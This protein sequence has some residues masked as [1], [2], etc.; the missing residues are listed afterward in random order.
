MRR[1]MR[2]GCRRRRLRARSE[3]LQVQ[4]RRCQ[5]YSLHPCSREAAHRRHR[6]HEPRAK[7]RRGRIRCEARRKTGR[8][9]ED[10]EDQGPRRR[11]AGKRDVLGPRRQRRLR[12]QSPAGQAGCAARSH[13]GGCDQ[14][15]RGTTSQASS[16][17]VV[18]NR[19]EWDDDTNAVMEAGGNPKTIGEY[20]AAIKRTRP[21]IY[22]WEWTGRPGHGEMCGSGCG[23]PQRLCRCLPWPPPPGP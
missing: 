23:V 3:V 10:A 1:H 2:Q 16:E 4:C 9:K 15:A 13:R 7:Q 8:R 20:I 14:T 19:K 21:W 18:E 22:V 12:I 5:Q 11:L 17:L 6:D